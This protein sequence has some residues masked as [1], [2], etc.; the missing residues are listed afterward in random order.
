MNKLNRK[1]HNQFDKEFFNKQAKKKFKREF[2]KRISVTE[3]NEIVKNW[4]EYGVIEDVLKGNCTKLDKNSSIQV[5][6][7]PIM[8]DGRMVELLSNGK[9]LTRKGNY[10]KADNINSKRKDFKYKIVYTNR[11][12][13]DKLIMF[14]ACP[15]FAKKVHLQLINTNTYFKLVV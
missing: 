14:K 5:I 2:K 15:K 13:E 3:I 12:A 1:L 4:I 6:G 11:L 9:C 8:N 10:K 7:T